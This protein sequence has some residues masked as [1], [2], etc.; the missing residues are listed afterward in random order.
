M[1]QAVKDHED[2]LTTGNLPEQVVKAKNAGGGT[3][4][5]GRSKTKRGGLGRHNNQIGV[6]EKQ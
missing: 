2:Y 3:P 5:F 6:E 1:K 4:G